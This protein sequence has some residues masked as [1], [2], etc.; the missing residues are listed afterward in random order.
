MTRLACAGRRER[1]RAEVVQ[2]AVHIILARAAAERA[3]AHFASPASAPSLAAA[4]ADPV[5]VAAVLRERVAR[6]GAEMSRTRARIAA[7]RPTNEPR[8]DVP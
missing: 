2:A 5:A 7:A 1:A 3:L 4:F 6:L 8:G